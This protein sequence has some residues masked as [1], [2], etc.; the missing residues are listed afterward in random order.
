MLPLGARAPWS[1]L[2]ALLLVRFADEW[3]TFFPAGAIE[4]IRADLGLTYAQ[5][6]LVV[7]SLPAGGLVG[8]AFSVAADFWDRRW[9]ASLGALGYALCLLAFALGGSFAVLLVAGFVWGAAGDA[10]VH[11]CEVT[12]VDLYDDDVAP[13]IGRVNAYAAVGDLLGPL[14]LAA[15]AALGL[16]WRAAFGFG[17]AAMLLYAGWLASQRFPRPSR[18]AEAGSPAQAVLAVVRDRRVLLLALVEGLYS[19]L[20]EPLL[21]FTAAFL[22]RD[23]AVPAVVATVA[24]SVGVVGGIA[25]FLAVP[26]FTARWA[27]GGL[28]RALAAAMAVELATLVLAPWLPLQTAALGLFELSGAVFYS[29]LTARYLSLRPGLAGTTGMV[30]GMVGHAG[31]GFPALVG[32]ASDAFGLAAGLGLYALVPVAILL[33]LAAGADAR[34]RPDIA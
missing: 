18:P 31:L 23:R 29:V 32:A 33:L 27:P 22:E 10:F 25:G 26:L 9:L 12:L 3:V 20:D 1:L 14:T 8:G 30:V 17:G 24:I 6:G 11:G 5:M 28:L 15:L 7:S 4:A 21:G 19:L 2:A 16:S 34:R 13:A